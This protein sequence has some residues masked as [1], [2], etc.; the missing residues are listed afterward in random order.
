MIMRITVIGAAGSA[1]SRIVKE[2]L[3]RGHQVT[4]AVR[5]IE[6]FNQLP[7]EAV[8]CLADA[9]LVNDVIR[10][11]KGQDLVIAATRPAEGQENDLLKITQSLIDGLTQSSVRL[12][13]MGGA[14]SLSV[15]DKENTLVVDDS[16]YVSPAWRDIAQACVEQ[17]QLYLA[18]Q[19]VDWSYISPAAMLVPGI[20]TG[21]F[22]LGKDELIIDNTGKSEISIE[23]LAV[24]IINEAEN[25]NFTQQRFTIGY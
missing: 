25:K 21:K 19:Q 9:S 22:R 10:V 16:R 6:Q 7:N 4:A 8:K 23:D 17:Y 14:G 24:A 18:S 13:A 1:G 12:I 15:K 20:R 3:A 11:S 5:S 2:A